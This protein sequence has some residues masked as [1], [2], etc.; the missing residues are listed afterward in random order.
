MPALAKPIGS[1]RPFVKM[2]E[3][4]F[5]SG[6]IPQDAQSGAIQLFGG[7]VEKQTDLVL[8]NL[9]AVLKSAGADCS[10]V[11]KTTVY[12]TSMADYPAINRAYSKVFGDQPPARATVAVQSLPKGVAVEIDAIAMA[13]RR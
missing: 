1:Y 10:Q 7:D 5:V 3:W 11:A 12:L 13:V 8:Q 2:G 9:A 6:Q 4:I